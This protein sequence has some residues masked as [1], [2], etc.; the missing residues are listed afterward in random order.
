MNIYHRTEK[1]IKTTVSNPFSS[2]QNRFFLP[3]VLVVLSALIYFPST[4]FIDLQKMTDVG[5]IPALPVTI[6]I[7]LAILLISFII[8]LTADEINEKV[9]FLHVFVLIFILYGTTL[10]VEEAPRFNV[11]WRHLGIIDYILRNGIVSDKIDAYFDWP[12]FF[13]LHAFITS[14]TGWNFL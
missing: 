8:C 7:A 12:G 6:Y 10:F 4:R 2:Y 9:I 5:L 14:T 11:T 3:L 1:K 13:V